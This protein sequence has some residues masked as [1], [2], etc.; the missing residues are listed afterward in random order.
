[1]SGLTEK[2]GLGLV[3]LLAY[4]SS[5]A[6]LGGNSHSISTIEHYWEIKKYI[7]WLYHPFQCMNQKHLIWLH[8][9]C[10]MS[11]VLIH[12]NRVFMTYRFCCQYCLS[13]LVSIL[14]LKLIVSYKSVFTNINLGPWKC[15]L[16]WPKTYFIQM[17]FLVYRELIFKWVHHSH[18]G[19]DSANFRQNVLSNNW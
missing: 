14:K 1:M 5:I 3:I 16:F 13:P 8:K 12:N 17:A 9:T 2:C 7:F 11:V 19:T 18:P 10:V 4:K 15:M 6:F